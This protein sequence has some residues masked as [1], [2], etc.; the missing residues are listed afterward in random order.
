VRKIRWL[1]ARAT[2]I[3]FATWRTLGQ[4]FFAQ[5]FYVDAPTESFSALRVKIF[6]RRNLSRDCRD[7]RRIKNSLAIL[8]V[9]NSSRC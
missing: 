4:T 7:V 5:K 9:V 8:F 3:F 6:L 2:E 1:R